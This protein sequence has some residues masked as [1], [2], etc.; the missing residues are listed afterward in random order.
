M[1]KEDRKTIPNM[2]D[3]ETPSEGYGT[4]SLS[5]LQILARA[6]LYSLSGIRVMKAHSLNVSAAFLGGY[7]H[8]KETLP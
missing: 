5:L 8:G 2:S 1:E 3:T 7:H 6:I 4:P